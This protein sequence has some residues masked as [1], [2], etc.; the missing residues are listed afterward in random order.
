MPITENGIEYSIPKEW[1][2]EI[3]LE[4]LKAFRDELFKMKYITLDG[5]NLEVKGG[6]E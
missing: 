1:L 4:F 3:D 5:L 6:V 2:K